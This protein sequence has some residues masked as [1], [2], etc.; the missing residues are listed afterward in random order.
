M[1]TKTKFSSCWV[2]IFLLIT[3]GHPNLEYTNIYSRHIQIRIDAIFPKPVKTVRSGTIS[4]TPV[5]HY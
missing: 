1:M 2:S 4:F 5:L 3:M